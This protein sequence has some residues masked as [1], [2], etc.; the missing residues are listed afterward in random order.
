MNLT[1]KSKYMAKLLRHA[2]ELGNLTIDRNGYTSVES[3]L[4]AL[5]INKETLD[6]IVKTDNKKRYSYDET[7]TLIRANQGH[8]L[9][10]VQIDFKKYIPTNHIYHGTAKK[11][12]DS[13]MEKGL[14]PG[15]RQ[16]VHLSKDLETATT[17][18]LRHGH[19]KDNIVIFEI[20][21]NK[22]IKDGYEFFISDNGVV[23][24]KSVPKEYLKKVV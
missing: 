12:E 14:I 11:F 4:K 8:S 21:Y 2:P 20:D 5:E 17:V 1:E 19:S 10:Y 15:S 24:I 7:G 13:I 18:G 9:P 3:L 23:L 22:M 6:E 16:Y